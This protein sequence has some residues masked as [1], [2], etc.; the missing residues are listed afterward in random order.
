MNNRA[1][2]YVIGLLCPFF[3]FVSTSSMAQTPGLPPAAKPGGA[4]PDLQQNPSAEKFVYPDFVYKNQT[5]ARGEDPNAPRMI[6]HGFKVVGVV[7]RKKLGITQKSIEQIVNDEAARIAPSK[8]PYGFT[9]NMFEDVADTVTR[10]Y[11]SKGFFLARAYIPE[12]TVKNGVV[13]LR[14][15]ETTLGEIAFKGNHLY[16]NEQLGKPFSGMVGKAI[17]RNTIESALFTLNDYPGLTAGGIFGPGSKPGTAAM[18]VDVNETPS[19]GYVSFD[20][21]GSVYTGENRLRLNYQLN[22]SLHRAE[23]MNFDLLTTI[24]AK[25][26][27]YGDFDYDE[28]VFNN[29][30]KTGGGV[31]VNTFAVGKQLADLNITGTSQIAYGFIGKQMWRKR[32][33]R[34]FTSLRLSLKKATS[35]IAGNTDGLDKLTVLKLSND[36]SAH[37]HFLG[38]AYHELNISLSVGLP[39]FLGSMDSTGSGT[40]TRT[41]GSGAHAGGNFTKITL[42][43]NR[44]QQLNRLQSILYRFDSQYTSNLLTS[45][46]QFSLGGPDTV[47][48]YPVADALT[49]RGAFYSVEWIAKSSPDIPRTW[50]NKLQLSLFV[51]YATGSTIDPLVN[52]L[53]SVSMGAIGIAAQVEP[54]NAMTARIDLSLARFGSAPVGDRTLPFYFR[55]VFPF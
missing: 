50:L 32:D 54:F 15:V 47:R 20:N 51:D 44:L 39:S 33:S 23:H 13:T 31:S 30:Y 2:R 19:S 42:S 10:F 38:N 26:S 41:G 29:K 22:N 12:Q 1:A 9:I 3:L 24:S 7:E 11:R 43:Y 35:K 8:K 17:Y 49:D 14:V 4:I 40:S 55:L 5:T 6:L 34:M 16:T 37:T 48:S 53:A 36:Y 25:H 52:E 28:P 27:I 45:L 46:E 21:Y 18:L